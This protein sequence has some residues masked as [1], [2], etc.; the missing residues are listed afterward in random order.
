MWKLKTLVQNVGRAILNVLFP[1]KQ[2]TQLEIVVLE[3]ISRDDSENYLGE[4]VK[5]VS[6]RLNREHDLMSICLIAEDFVNREYCTGLTIFREDPN[7]RARRRYEITDSGKAIL[8]KHRHILYKDAP[9]YQQ[10]LKDMDRGMYSEEER[11]ELHRQA[12]DTPHL[13]KLLAKK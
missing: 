12:Y 7:E 2:F 13:D 11:E 8:R 10:L 3:I 1:P 6:E 9:V 5:R 4:I